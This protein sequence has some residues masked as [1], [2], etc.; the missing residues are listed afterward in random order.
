MARLKVL[1][2]TKISLK[3]PVRGTPLRIDNFIKQIGQEHDIYVSALDIAENSKIKFFPYRQNSW[4]SNFFYFRNIIK[5]NNIKVLVT[6]TGTSIK[7]LVLLKLLCRVKIV[8]DLHGI[9]VEESYFHGYISNRQRIVKEFIFGFLLRFFDLLFAVS[10]KLKNY[11]S[12]VNKNIEVIYGGVNLAEFSLAMPPKRDF[13][14]IGYMGNTRVYQG[15]NEIMAAVIKIKK[16]N[17]FPFRLNM[18]ISGSDKDFDQIKKT[19]ADNDLLSLT[20][21]HFNV[22]H[23]KVDE[24]INQ[25]D[26]LVLPRPAGIKMTEY[27]YPSKLPEYLATGLVTITTDVGPVSELFKNAQSCL[28][29]STDNIE[30]N[31]VNALRQVFA[32]S[33]DKRQEIG[34]KGREFVQNNLTWDILGKKINQSLAKLS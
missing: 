29:I 9:D 24:I 20:S 30:Q 11:Y 14:L 17:I 5:Q 7:L 8:M 16:E 23:D 6:A 31:L 25:S 28:V 19:L 15:L 18:V 10:H 3:N 34:R 13:L 33:L 21:L 12:S 27:A 26:V 2:I 22:D 1:F 4:W 32:M